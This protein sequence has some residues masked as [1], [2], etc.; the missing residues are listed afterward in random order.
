MRTRY[1]Y[2]VVRKDDYTDKY[3]IRGAFS[4]LRRANLAVVQMILEERKNILARDD[5]NEVL[6]EKDGDT[7]TVTVTQTWIRAQWRYK[8]LRLREDEAITLKEGK[9]GLP[10]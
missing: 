5:K 1:S 9:D 4:S 3:T 2:V 6:I 10:E 7:T 8:V